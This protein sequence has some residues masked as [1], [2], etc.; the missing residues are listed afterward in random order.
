MVVGRGCVTDLRVETDV[1][2]ILKAIKGPRSAKTK[3][4][5]NHWKN[6]DQA[7][8]EDLLRVRPHKT[9]N[10][11]MDKHLQN[12]RNILFYSNATPIRKQTG[13]GYLCGFCSEEFI[14]PKDLKTHTLQTHDNETKS[15]FMK[16]CIM[17]DYIV[18]L[19]ITGLQCEICDQNIDGLKSLMNHLQSVHY[20]IIHTDIKNHI[21]GFKFEGDTLQCALCPNTY[22]HFKLLQEHMN[23]HHNNFNCEICSSPFVNKRTLGSHMRRHKQGEFPCSFCSKVFDTNLRKLCHERF[24][25]I[26]DQKTNKCP[27]CNEKFVS[28]SQR[29]EHMVKEHGAKPLVFKCKACDKTFASK[30]TLTRHTKRVHLLERRNECEYCDMK[31]FRKKDL[32][33]HM[34]KH[35]GDREYSCDICLKAF[36]RKDHLQEHLRIH[37][38][39]RKYRCNLCGLPFVQK[40]SWR[41]HMKTRHNKQV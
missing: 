31:F 40:A 7:F 3:D 39:D 17:F 11:E 23:V 6:S 22:D 8:D 4:S 25:H 20:K 15:S 26:L 24:I 19:D 29:N 16:G 34:L 41:S 1:S 36:A 13:N 28:Y 12:I 37:A 18:K 9:D 33:I 32:T 2:K 21:L 30:E 27:Q 14:L 35:T 10:R 38:E 5:K